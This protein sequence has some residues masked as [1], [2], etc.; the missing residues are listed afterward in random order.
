M[1][2]VGVPW[3]G[4]HLLQGTFTPTTKMDTWVHIPLDHP[5]SLVATMYPGYN[6]YQYNISHL[7]FY[8]KKKY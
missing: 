6:M 8:K 3:L 1:L 2:D 5:S 7:S 4:V